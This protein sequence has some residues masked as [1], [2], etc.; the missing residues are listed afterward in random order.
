[1]VGSDL[2]PSVARD[3]KELENAAFNS[4]TQAFYVRD[5]CEFREADDQDLVVRAQELVAR[6]FRRGLSVLANPQAVQSFLHLHL[7][8]LEHMRF[9]ALFLDRRKRLLAYRGLFRGTI[10]ALHVHPR[11]VVRDALACNAVCV[12]LVRNDPSGEAMFSEIDGVTWRRVSEALALVDIET[13]DYMLVG[14]RVMSCAEEGWIEKKRVF[15]RQ[16]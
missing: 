3:R 2:I 10:D 12:I 8:P 16:S 1:M 7:A 6:R 4:P 15:W 9:A 14:T 13:L 11:E 5:G